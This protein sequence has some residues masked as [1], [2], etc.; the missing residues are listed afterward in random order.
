MINFILKNNMFYFNANYYSQRKGTAMG[1][2]FAPV[3]A[4]LVIGYLEEKHYTQVTDRFGQQFKEYFITYWKRFLDDC[5]MPW[6]RSED[7][8][9]EL[10]TIL[11]NLHNDINFTIE[12]SCNH[13]PFLDVLVQKRGT[14]IET[15]VYYKQMDS[16]S[17][18]TFLSCHPKHLKTSIPFS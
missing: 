14:K 18:L 5:F 7:D 10:H 15:D 2:K 16:K 1:T 4:T 8:L 17:Y 13:L 9:I 11:N 3:Y 12:Y 6:T